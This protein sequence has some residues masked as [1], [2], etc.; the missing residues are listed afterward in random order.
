MRSERCQNSC[1][2]SVR[3][4]SD[5]VSSKSDHR[6]PKNEQETKYVNDKKSTDYLHVSVEKS[7]H[8]NDY[9]NFSVLNKE[10]RLDR[11]PG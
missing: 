10:S 4:D 9:L 2:G 3:I 6:G 7:K 8:V 11:V 5:Q 1:G